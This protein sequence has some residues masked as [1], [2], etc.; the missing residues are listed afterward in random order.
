M[1]TLEIILLIALIA[2]LAMYITSKLGKDKD[3]NEVIKEVKSDLIKT[4]INVAELISKAKNIVFDESVQK[5]I[6][7]F[8]LIVEEKNKL[9]RD[10]GEAFLSGD[11]KK[12]AVLSR[13]SEWVSNVTGSVENAVNFVETNQ[14]R[15][16]SAIEDYISFSNKMEGKATLSE[17]EKIIQKQLNKK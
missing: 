2:V 11:D 4:T 14:S 10:K 5:A 16:D 15:I 9:A 1:T 17:A 6:K 3:L 7:E 13:L 8:I 12:K